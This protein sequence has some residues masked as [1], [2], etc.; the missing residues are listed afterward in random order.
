MGKFPK[1]ILQTAIIISIF[2]VFPLF[3]DTFTETFDSVNFRDSV[4][5]TIN[6]NTVE[7]YAVLGRQ[8]IFAET[9]GV[10][11]WGGGVLSVRYDSGLSRWLI[12]G[13]GGKINEHDGYNFI[14]RSTGLIGFGTSDIFAIGS[15]GSMFL[16]GGSGA[17]LNSYNGSSWSDL[18]SNLTGFGDV[19][20][21]GYK[22]TASTHWL[23]G[24]TGA[25]LNRYDGT[26][27]TNLKTNLTSSGGFGSTDTVYTL[28]FGSSYWLIGGQN[29][30]LA[31]YDGSST[32]ANLAADLNTCWGGAY[33][34]YSVAWDG[35][36][37]L[38][39][40]GNGRLASYNGTAFTNLSSSVSF[41]NI[42]SISWNGSFWV[43]AG[44]DGSST[45]IVTYD[46]TT[47]YQKSN[48]SYYN[49]DPVWAVGS[50]T[51]TGDSIMGG[52]NARIMKRN[53]SASSND[54]ANDFTNYTNTVRD[55][56]KFNILCSGYNSSYWL[57][58]GVSG[59]LNRYDGTTFTD[60]TASLNWGTNSVT[61]VKWNGS[62]WLIGGTNGKLAH[63]DGSAFTD[64]TTNLN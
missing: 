59:R 1:I 36:R 33:D 56:G 3:A 42:W 13:E 50:N 51:S 55:F 61:S 10:L 23:I 38:I 48:P 20:A 52:R 19:R 54:A 29:G 57:I 62:Y 63:Y 26:N 45:R 7:G 41:T 25:A 12:G 32:W 35:T 11:N 16:I 64:R 44:A 6:W 9:T 40:G 37:W 17:K 21:I 30:K 24:G 22:T 60:L 14:N 43:I 4:N 15:N 49:A 2:S 8:D 18:S 27:W 58:G 39:G 47:F 34:V 53:A 28:A 46:N 31:R 5:T